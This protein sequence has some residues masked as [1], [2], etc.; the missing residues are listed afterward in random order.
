MIELLRRLW[1]AFS[2]DPQVEYQRAKDL[3]GRRLASPEIS[4]EDRKGEMP[5]SN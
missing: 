5:E 4:P 1:R 2:Y 3:L